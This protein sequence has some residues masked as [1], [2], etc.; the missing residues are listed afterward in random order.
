VY[1]TVKPVYSDCMATGYRKLHSSIAIKIDL[2][3]L[4]V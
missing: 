4:Q 2:R 3:Q 1:N